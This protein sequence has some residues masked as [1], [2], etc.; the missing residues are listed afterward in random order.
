MSLVMLSCCGVDEVKRVP[1]EN[2]ERER[3]ENE[4]RRPADEKGTAGLGRGG[5]RGGGEL[6]ACRRF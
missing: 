2:A 6:W 5:Q 1:C 3:D 4:K